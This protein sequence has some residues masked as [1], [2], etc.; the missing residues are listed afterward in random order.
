MFKESIRFPL[1]YFLVSTV[2]HF[3]SNKEIAWIENIIICFIMFLMIMFF[4]WANTPFDWKKN[5]T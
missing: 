1:I 4:R 3:I 2:W 5:N